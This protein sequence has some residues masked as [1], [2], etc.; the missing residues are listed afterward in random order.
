LLLS[1]FTRHSSKSKYD[2]D[3]TY[4]RCNCPKW[5]GGQIN[6]DYFGESAGTRQ[7]NDAEEYR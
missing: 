5:I 4:R 1:V 6:R 7:W 2:S 3:R